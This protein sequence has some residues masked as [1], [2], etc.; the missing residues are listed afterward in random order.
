M[1]KIPKF[2]QI[3]KADNPG[4]EGVLRRGIRRILP[5]VGKNIYK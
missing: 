3:V 2:L 5:F 1:V 4:S